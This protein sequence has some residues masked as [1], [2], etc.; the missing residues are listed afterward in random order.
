VAEESDSGPPEG[1]Y[2]KLRQQVV[3]WGPDAL[4]RLPVPSLVPKPRTPDAL[5]GLPPE[6]LQDPLS[7]RLKNALHSG[8]AS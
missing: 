2:L 7:L 8:D 3:R 4:P 5:P 1:D 6:A